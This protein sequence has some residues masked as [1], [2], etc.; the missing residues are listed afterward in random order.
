VTIPEL[1]CLKLVRTVRTYVNA[2][3]QL[4]PC[5]HESVSEEKNCQVPNEITPGQLVLNFVLPQFEGKVDARTT[6]RWE[7]E[8]NAEGHLIPVP[9]RLPGGYRFGIVATMISTRHTTRLAQL[10][11]ED[12]PFYVQIRV[13]TTIEG[14]DRTV[15]AFLNGPRQGDNFRVDGWETDIVDFNREYRV[16]T[17]RIA[18]LQVFIKQKGRRPGYGFG[19]FTRSCRNCFEGSPGGTDVIT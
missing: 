14:L 12:T 19:D 17:H 2:T 4:F 3:W 18:K 16:T 10:G 15:T 6:C 5:A 13:G 11:L 1:A 7:L 8:R 9:E